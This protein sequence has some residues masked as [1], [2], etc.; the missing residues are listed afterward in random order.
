MLNILVA[1]TAIIC[2]MAMLMAYRS[3]KD[4]FHPAILIAPM[5]LFLYVYMPSKLINSSELLNFVSEEQAIFY[6]F[7]IVVTLAL[8]FAGMISGSQYRSSD[9]TRPRLQV[10]KKKLQLG[11]YIFGYIGFLAFA[12][13]IHNA[14]GFSE[15]FGVKY[16]G[17]WSD[18]GYIRDAAYLTIVGMVLL[19]SREAFDPKNK[20]WLISI[21]LFS[22]PWL[23]YGLLGARRGPTFMVAVCVGM[24]WFLARGKRPSIFSLAVAGSTLGF[25]MLFLVTNRDH[26]CLKCDLKLTTDMS[27]VTSSVDE[28]N[29]YIFGT[30][31]VAASRATNKCYWGRRYLAQIT[32]RPIPRQIWPTKYEDT[33]LG[34]LLQNAGVAGRGLMAVMGWGEV[35]GAAASMVA[36]LWVEFSWLELPVAFLLGWGFGRVWRLGVT[37]MG[38]WMTE[39]VILCILSVYF[40][41]QSGEAVISRSVILTVPAILTWRLSRIPGAYLSPLEVEAMDLAGSNRVLHA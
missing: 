39:F 35:P 17:G 10:N 22:F 7:L 41:S 24:S 16:G 40:V 21:G 4:V 12:Y 11:G 30:G 3:Y 28:G 29:E 23:A 14:G 15:A 32:V 33:G 13:T 1:L 6:Q 20:L 26:I 38:F 25:L 5:C 36:D 18:I 19:L 2:I 34:D 8:L 27:T 31:C 9:K 37:E